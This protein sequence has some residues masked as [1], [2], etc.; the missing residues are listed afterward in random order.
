MGS[1]CWKLAAGVFAVATLLAGCDHVTNSPHRSG[2]E[3]TNTFF[4]AFQ[5]RSPKYLDSDG[6]VLARRDALHL[7]DLRAARTAS[8][9]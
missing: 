3:R 8:T 5:E 9:T 6:L 2:E 7:L 1:V 4:T